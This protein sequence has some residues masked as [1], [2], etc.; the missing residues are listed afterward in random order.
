[1]IKLNRL[2][3]SEPFVVVSLCVI[4]HLSFAL[5]VVSSI[6]IHHIHVRRTSFDAC[7]CESWL[8]W[9]TFHSSSSL[10]CGWRY[11]WCAD[12]VA[13]SI[14]IE[15]YGTK[16]TYVKS[17]AMCLAFECILTNTPL[18]RLYF[19]ISVP[20]GRACFVFDFV[21]FRRW[22]EF[23]TNTFKCKT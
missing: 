17:E 19:I 8:C 5:W 21:R 23:E 4:S 15:F 1:M 16:D 7:D 14:Q 9:K 2:R 18:Y 22:V 3:V 12:S 11:R 20:S 10:T 13:H 6:L